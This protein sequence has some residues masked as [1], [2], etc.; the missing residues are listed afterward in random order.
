MCMYNSVLSVVN[1]LSRLYSCNIIIAIGV[2][3]YHS[4]YD[5]EHAVSLC[6]EFT[7]LTV[8]YKHDYFHVHVQQQA[9]KQLP[10]QMGATM[11]VAVLALPHPTPQLH[12]RL[13]STFR[14][15]FCRHESKQ[16]YHFYFRNLSR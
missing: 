11:C 8:E 6:P 13:D 2:Q 12:V 15:A 4:V 14:I 10:Q 16:N 9:S 3:G 7:F 5:L 1:N